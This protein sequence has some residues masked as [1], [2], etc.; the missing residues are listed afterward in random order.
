MPKYGRRSSPAIRSALAR[1]DCRPRL[2]LLARTDGDWREE[3]ANES[4]HLDFL[5]TLQVIALG[6]LE[7]EPIGRR[8]AWQER[9]RLADRPRRSS[10]LREIDWPAVAAGSSRLNCPGRQLDHP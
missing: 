2:L 6:S 7:P 4:S 8:E 9:H 10:R 5:T 3:H 1:A